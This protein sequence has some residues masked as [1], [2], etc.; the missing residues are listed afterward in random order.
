MIKRTA[1][2]VGALGIF[3]LLAFGS[4]G[5]SS[6]DVDWSELNKAIDEANNAS[7]SSSSSG[8]GGNAAACKSYVE[9]MNACM[10]EGAKM[11]ADQTCPSTLD[12]AGA[13]DMSGY[14]KC[15]ADNAKC[16]GGIPDVSGQMNCTMPTMLGTSELG[17]RF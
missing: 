4:G 17:S 12:M 3:T 5:G 8:G 6:S 7:T 16:S 14:Y 9:A 13:L 2:S 15:M 1:I 11:N 10:P